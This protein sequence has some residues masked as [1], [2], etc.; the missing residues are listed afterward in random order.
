LNAEQGV[1]FSLPAGQ[2]KAVVLTHV[3]R[4]SAHK[5]CCCTSAPSVRAG[6]ASRASK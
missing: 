4:S 2:E 6:S 3:I 5:L 1:A